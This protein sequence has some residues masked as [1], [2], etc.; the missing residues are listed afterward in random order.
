[1]S[2]LCSVAVSWW[3]EVNECCRERQGFLKDDG[4][5]KEVVR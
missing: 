4:E 5:W 1:M 2:L 3:E